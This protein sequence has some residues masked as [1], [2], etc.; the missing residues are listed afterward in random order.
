MAKEFNVIWE[1]RTMELSWGMPTRKPPSMPLLEQLLEQQRC[2]ALS[3]A[4]L[5]G[6]AND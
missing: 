5:V 4:V 3:T 2:M 1:Q 6:E